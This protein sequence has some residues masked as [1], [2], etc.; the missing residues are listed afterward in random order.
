MDF[1]FKKVADHTYTVDLPQLNAGE[2]GFLAPG[3]AMQSHASAQLGKIYTFR[4][5]E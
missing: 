2:Y 4:V 5:L 1:S 3:S